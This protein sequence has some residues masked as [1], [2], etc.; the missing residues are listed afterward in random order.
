MAS[1]QARRSPRP[2]ERRRCARRPGW[3]AAPRA[4]RADRGA[5]AGDEPLRRDR[6]VGEKAGDHRLGHHPGA[7]ERDSHRATWTHP[8]SFSSPTRSRAAAISSASP[9]PRWKQLDRDPPELACHGDVRKLQLRAPHAERSE[10]LLALRAEVAR[11]VD[12][13]RIV[14][15]CAGGITGGDPDVT[16]PPRGADGGE[17]HLRT[18]EMPQRAVRPRVGGPPCAELGGALGRR[19]R[20]RA[21][22]AM[23]TGALGREIRDRKLAATEDRGQRRDPAAGRRPRRG[24][25]RPNARDETADGRR[26]TAGG[27][28]LAPSDGR[29]AGQT[30]TSP[31][32]PAR[33][34][35]S[36]ARSVRS[37][38][39]SRSVRPKWPSAA[40]LR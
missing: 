23:V 34:R 26:E 12:R 4:P 6:A 40:V 20:R 15:A 5:M 25:E 19:H 9:P 39:R 36:A 3:S 8:T 1:P 14:A 16:D 13:L 7:D 33:S 35:S 32:R 10:S 11:L 30:G 31:R 29:V 24:D 37:Q 18:L 22:A 21:G 38:G 27:M 28:C 2:R 17:L